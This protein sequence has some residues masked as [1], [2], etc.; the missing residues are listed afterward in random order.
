MTLESPE[1][2]KPLPD[3]DCEY[4][5]CPRCKC[6]AMKEYWEWAGIP[7]DKLGCPNCGNVV[8]IGEWIAGI[9]EAKP[10]QPCVVC[11]GTGRIQ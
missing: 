9:P 5:K 4:M 7:E 10:M 1:Y 2:L 6:R 8:P 11:S 3:S